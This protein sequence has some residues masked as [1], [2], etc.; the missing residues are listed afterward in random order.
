MVVRNYVIAPITEELI[1]RGVLSAVLHNCWPL[2]ATLLISSLEFGFAHSHHYI[3][4]TNPSQRASGWAAF[5]Q[6]VYTSLFGNVCLFAVLQIQTNSDTN[7]GPFVLQFNGFTRLSTI[8]SSRFSLIL[9]IFGLFSWILSVSY[10]YINYDFSR[11][12][13]N[14]FKSFIESKVV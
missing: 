10:D 13:L 7:S 12:L 1:F 14:Y 5:E 9:T 4:E 3:F 8:S 6:M 2:R 11:F